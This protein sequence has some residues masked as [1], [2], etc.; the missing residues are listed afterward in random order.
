MQGP[1]IQIRGDCINGLTLRGCAI[2][3]LGL[4]LVGDVVLDGCLYTHALDSAHCESP[5][6]I[7][8]R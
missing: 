3:P 6:A 7:P 5:V 2:A 1:I 4:L 8:A